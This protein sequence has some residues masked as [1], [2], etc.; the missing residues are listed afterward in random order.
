MWGR[1]GE[2]E[3]GGCVSLCINSASLRQAMSFLLRKHISK[4]P[5]AERLMH[6]PAQRIQC[7]SSEAD[8]MNILVRWI[9]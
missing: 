4:V 7:T 6:P 1:A 8:A 5:P 2:G 3:G 9:Q